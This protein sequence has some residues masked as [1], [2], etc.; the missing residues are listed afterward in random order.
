[1]NIDD[2][3]GETPYKLGGSD[4]NKQDVSPEEMAIDAAVIRTGGSTKSSTV[5]CGGPTSSQNDW[6]SQLQQIVE[7][8]TP[9]NGTID[10]GELLAAVQRLCDDYMISDLETFSC[11]GHDEVE[12]YV[13]EKQEKHKKSWRTIVGPL[14]F[15]GIRTRFN[16]VVDYV[17]LDGDL[18]KAASINVSKTLVDAYYKPQ[19]GVAVAAG[20]SSDASVSV[21]DADSHKK[22]VP[23]LSI[24]TY[25][26][27]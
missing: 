26:S 6:P 17:H 20:A 24:K 13:K 12:T 23:K 1:M 14:Q 16:Y 8:A 22:T 2:I 4:G 3:D 21:A 7:I 18:A 27:L 19:G 25:L 5:G 11:L 10:K 15:K 9:P